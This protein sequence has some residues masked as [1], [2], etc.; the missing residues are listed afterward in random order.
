M[1]V[2]CSTLLC[3]VLPTMAGCAVIVWHSASTSDG[4]GSTS[5]ARS[6]EPSEDP[7]ASLGASAENP[8]PAGSSITFRTQDEGTVDIALSPVTWDATQIVAE[9][10]PYSEAAPAGKVYIA[11]TVSLT[12]H[13]SAPFDPGGEVLLQYVTDSG[14]IIY[15]VPVMTDRSSAVAPEMSDGQSAS[16]DEYFLIDQSA[17]RT[18]SLQLCV[19]FGPAPYQWYEAA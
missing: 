15:P 9:G 4:D 11:V 6:R 10:D 17:V 7:S 2:G 13:G 3:L 8:Y 16:F 1:L 18:G 12:Y 19:L 5:S 14:E